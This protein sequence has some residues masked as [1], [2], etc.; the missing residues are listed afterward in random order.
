MWP[1]AVSLGRRCPRHPRGG[2]HLHL[3]PHSAHQ[4]SPLTHFFHLPLLFFITPFLSSVVALTLSTLQKQQHGISPLAV[5]LFERKPFPSLEGDNQGPFRKTTL[6]IPIRQT[7]CFLF[8]PHSHTAFVATSRLH[9]SPSPLLSFTKKRFTTDWACVQREV[10]PFPGRM[11]PF[12]PRPTPSAQ[13]CRAGS[14]AM[15]SRFGRPA[16][17]ASDGGKKRKCQCCDEGNLLGTHRLHPFVPHALSPRPLCESGERWEPER[18]QSLHRARLCS[19]RC[20][21]HFLHRR[22]FAQS[23]VGK[24]GCTRR[25]VSRENREEGRKTHWSRPARSPRPS[26]A[27]PP[28]CTGRSPSPPAQRHRQRV[29]FPSSWPERE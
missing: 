9:G 6:F 23:S 24:V 28:M 29:P 15:R 4:P 18:L 26:L 2:A 5:H 3:V 11:S 27:A 21:H 14:R 7:W 17:P 1:R 19:F 10:S 20:H 12:S 16:P 22:R 13:T 25:L 8:S